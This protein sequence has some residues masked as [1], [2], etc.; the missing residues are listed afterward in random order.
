M[1]EVGAT[2]GRTVLFVSHN[3]TAI[4]NLCPKA[5]YLKNGLIQSIGDTDTVMN[6]YLSHNNNSSLKQFFDNPES[7]PGNEFVKMKRM[8]VVP[9]FVN[10]NEPITIHT[11]INIEFE[12]WNYRE[13]VPINLSLVLNTLQSECVFNVYTASIK[14][15]KG[16]H[17]GVCEIPA[18]LLNDG[19]YSISMMVVGEKSYSIFYFEDVVGFE[20]IE[21]REGSNWHGKHPGLVRPSLNFSLNKE[22]DK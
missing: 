15:S 17:K 4:K 2:E 16:L 12:F 13:D 5:M 22:G 6:E 1:K 8:E 11:P 18:N 21:K 14:L 19:A 9:Q 7:A 20:V 10:L 3:M